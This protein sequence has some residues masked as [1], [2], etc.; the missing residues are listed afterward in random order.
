MRVLILAA[1]CLMAGQASAETS[2][3]SAESWWRDAEWVAAVGQC[4]GALFTAIAAWLAFKAVEATRHASKSQT[5]GQT[6]ATLLVRYAEPQMYKALQEFGRFMTHD[7]GRPDREAIAAALWPEGGSKQCVRCRY[8]GLMGTTAKTSTRRML[9]LLGYYG[10]ADGKP[11][12]TDAVAAAKDLIAHRRAI[13]HHFKLVWAA[14]HSGVL[15]T[16]HLP[17]VT[18]ANY[19]YVLWLQ[20]VLPATVV[21]AED[22]KRPLPE[23]PSSDW[24]IEWPW[25][26]IQ[27]VERAPRVY[28][29]R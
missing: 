20:A 28:P 12:G 4:A 26:L 19:G 7:V 1:C 27:A 3:S 21:M 23:Q 16:E 18:S 17:L 14:L 5:E 22:D 24:D 13:H 15:S 11:D 29:L 10:T 9:A 2:G 6:V 8:V 25:D